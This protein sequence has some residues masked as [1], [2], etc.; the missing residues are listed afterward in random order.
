MTDYVIDA[1]ILVEI[2]VAGTERESCLKFLESVAA[3]RINLYA[4]DVIYY[5]VVGALRKH[6]L[7]GDY[8]SMGEDIALLS[9]LDLVTT[10]AKELLLPTAQIGR[11]HAIGIYDAF[12]LALSIRLS[13]P[14]MTVDRRLINATAGKPFQVTFV[15]DVAL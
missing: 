14:L 13:L 5:E 12:Y 6:E 7:R 3:K 10:S 11:Q 4:P 2:F 9:D 15:A 1:S 8:A